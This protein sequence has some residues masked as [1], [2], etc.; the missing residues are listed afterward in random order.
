METKIEI[1]EHTEHLRYIMNFET[2]CYAL[3]GHSLHD[4]FGAGLRWDNRGI[5]ECSG[6]TE[7]S[8]CASNTTR[9]DNTFG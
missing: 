1:V 5:I 2:N 4:N 7:Y 3:G 6:V 8:I 9:I